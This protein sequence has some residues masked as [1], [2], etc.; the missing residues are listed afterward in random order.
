[1]LLLRSST[2]LQGNVEKASALPDLHK[3]ELELEALCQQCQASP[4]SFSYQLFSADRLVKGSCC[5][6]CF[7]DL[8]R[9]LRCAEQ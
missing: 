1:M 3:P 5:P 4:A 8:L 7:L 9:G 6:G 2:E